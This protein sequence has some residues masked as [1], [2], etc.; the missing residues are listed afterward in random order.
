MSADEPFTPPKKKPNVLW[1]IA[2]GIAAL[3]FIFF[4]QLFGPNPP[5]VVSRQT[6]HIMSP[7]GPDGLPDYERYLL[8]QSRQGITP[9]NNAAALIWAALWPGELDPK[10]Q[11]AV[12]AELG[13]QS[14]PS[15]GESLDYLQGQ[16]NE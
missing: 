11:A 6:T 7:L 3:V 15:P 1:W 16:R 10:Q 8:E 12:A 9:E 5:I 14:I 4:L 13:L 2:G